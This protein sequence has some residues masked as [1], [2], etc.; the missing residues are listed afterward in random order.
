MMTNQNNGEQFSLA[1]LLKIA[2]DAKDIK[3]GNGIT[4]LPS[5][6][7]FKIHTAYGGIRFDNYIKGRYKRGQELQRQADFK[8]RDYILSLV[9]MKEKDEWLFVGIYRVLDPRPSAKTVREGV[10]DYYKYETEEILGLED[11]VGRV[12]ISHQGVRRHNIKAEKHMDN[13]LQV[14]RILPWDLKSGKGQN[15]EKMLCKRGIML[16]PD[17]D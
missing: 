8:Q 7:N 11:L 12:V 9:E 16:R 1:D 2:D 13:S 15:F 4:S 14:V 10:K 6:D 3:W 17:K 5:W